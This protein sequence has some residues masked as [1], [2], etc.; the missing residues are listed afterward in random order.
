MSR[1]LSYSVRETK[2]AGSLFEVRDGGEL[3]FKEAPTFKD[4]GADVFSNI[5]SALIDVEDDDPGD[6]KNRGFDE[7]SRVQVVPRF[8]AASLS[9]A[10]EEKRRAGGGCRGFFGPEPACDG[11]A[12]RRGGCGAVRVVGSGVEF[13]GG[14][15]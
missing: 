8:S 14:H 5:Y 4:E 11:V 13:Q 7:V 3:H 9:G 12:R 10:A 1:E 2:L 6:V 15:G